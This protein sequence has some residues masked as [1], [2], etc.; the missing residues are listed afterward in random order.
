MAKISL[1][2]V[3]TNVQMIL[4][5]L[6]KGTHVGTD[7][8][9]NRYFKGKARKG[10][11]RERRW[12]IYKAGHEASTVPALWHGWLH[13]QSNLLPEAAQGYKKPWQKP[14]VA[15]MTGSDKAYLPQ[16]HAQRGGERAASS[17]DY[18]PWQPPA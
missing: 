8:F 16:G 13:H 10:T 1:F 4:H 11:S 6:C 12:V 14:H 2:G 17:S 15:N 5:T 18:T 3:L 9:G 7:E